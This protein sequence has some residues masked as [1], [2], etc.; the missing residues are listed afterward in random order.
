MM[1]LKLRKLLK[2][3]KKELEK[4]AIIIKIKQEN[5]MLKQK[6]DESEKKLK[7]IGEMVKV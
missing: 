6:L 1:Q 7:D 4:E 3:K 2:I 5:E